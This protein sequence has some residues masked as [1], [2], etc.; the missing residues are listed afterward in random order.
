MA[1]LIKQNELQKLGLTAGEL[2]SKFE[3]QLLKDFAT[4]NVEQFLQPISD[5]SYETIQANI[6]KALEQ[7]TDN[8]FSSYQQLLYTIDISERLLKE[9]TKENA[10]K[11]MN[12]ILADLIIKR[13]LQKIILKKVY[14]W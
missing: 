1:D 7:I 10:D 13:I 5:F 14:S 2:Q 11:N 12:D 8:N 9:K 6:S 3:T 4:A